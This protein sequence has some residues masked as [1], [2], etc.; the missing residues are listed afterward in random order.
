MRLMTGLAVHQGWKPLILMS[1]SIT[2]PG[3]LLQG[4]IVQLE[5]ELNVDLPPGTIK[6]EYH[7]HS[8]KTPRILTPEEFKTF[9]M[10]DGDSPTMPLNKEP[11]HPFCSREDFELAEIAH[12]ASLSS[13]QL[14]T[15]VK[16]I[17][18]CEKNPGA[19][20]FKGAQDVEQSWEDASRLLMPV[21]SFRAISLCP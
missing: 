5:A 4:L 10:S 12:S 6:I 9:L 13:A 11:W 14:D 16:L 20:T 18:R 19:L 1:V 21:S 17:K 15:L 2:I 3:A 7:P 8:G